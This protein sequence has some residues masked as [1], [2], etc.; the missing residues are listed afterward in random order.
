MTEHPILFSGEMVRAILDGCKTQTRRIVKPQPVAPLRFS[1]DRPAV[2][3]SVAYFA[4][5]DAGGVHHNELSAECRY[6]Q[7][8]D[9]LWVR[10]TWAELD[11]N[12]H[13]KPGGGRVVYRADHITGNDGPDKI[14]WRPSIFMPRWAS[15]IMLEVVAVRVERVQAI[16]EADAE[17]EGT[18]WNPYPPD[19]HYGVVEEYKK[20]W[21]KINGKRAPW[22][23]NP[24]VWVVEFTRVAP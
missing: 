16:S 2:G 1:I 11:I 4:Y 7:S 10:E 24:W 3:G 13:P 22:A 19:N 8:G 23:D 20:L 6:G 14:T 18:H 17:A 15:R 9:H 5:V 12:Y 21:D